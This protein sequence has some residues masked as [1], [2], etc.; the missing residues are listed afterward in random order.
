MPNIRS[1]YIK[2]VMANSNQLKESMAVVVENALSAIMGE[3]TKRKFRQII[4]EGEDNEFEVEEVD[5]TE[6]PAASEG[7][8]NDDATGGG[9]GEN[10]DGGEGEGAEPGE[11]EN[12]DTEPDADP[13]SD[14]GEGGEG[15]NPEED[16]WAALEQYR[17]DDGEYDL[18]KCTDGDCIARVLKIMGPEDGVRIEDNGDGSLTLTDDNTEQEYIIQMP[19]VGDGAETV[20]EGAVNVGI[21]DGYQDKTAMTVSNN[22]ETANPSTT[23][24]MDKGV[25]T[26][27]EKPFAGDGDKSPFNQTVKESDE[28]IE[29]QLDDENGE[30]VN[31][32]MTTQENGAYNRGDGMLHGNTNIGKA[33][34]GREASAGGQKISGTVDNSYSPKHEAIMRKANAIFTENKQLKAKLQ[35]YESKF[36]EIVEDNKKMKA[37]NEDLQKR[38]EKWLVNTQS[39]ANIVRLMTESPLTVDEKKNL[40]KE[41]SKA[42]DIRESNQ[43]YESIKA[44]MLQNPRPA[45]N[46]GNPQ[47]MQVV[48]SRQ[49][50]G[51]REQ[52]YENDGLGDALGLMDR[53]DSVYR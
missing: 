4:N 53:M 2:N 6:N 46:I 33:A 17:G 18:T 43:L 36:N 5:D 51:Q 1:E 26:G 19:E 23:Y 50:F 49:Q 31:E 39:L 47:A 8:G 21:T 12:G 37:V 32:T 27:T 29:I 44:R 34:D 41:F 15:E 45:A 7:D 40:V 22:N 30:N 10:P 38:T 16:P 25:P 11:G 13:I 14:N 52:V 42:K 20:S 28:T 35:A 3:D 48:E 24:S 9:E